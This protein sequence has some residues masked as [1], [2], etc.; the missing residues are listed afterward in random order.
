[1]EL[2]RKERRGWRKRRE[3][4]GTT[5]QSR[6]IYGNRVSRPRGKRGK[7]THKPNGCSRSRLL[8]PD[9]QKLKSPGIFLESLGILD[10]A[11]DVACGF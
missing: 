2:G 8:E 6:G 7:L 9:N 3:N 10:F 11:Q 5:P 1:M 4:M